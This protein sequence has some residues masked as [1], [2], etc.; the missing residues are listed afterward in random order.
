MVDAGKIE[1]SFKNGL[2]VTLPKKP[3]AQKPTKK[4]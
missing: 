3:G 2:K 1:A 4:P